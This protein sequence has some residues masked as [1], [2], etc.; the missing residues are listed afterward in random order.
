MLYAITRH[1][2]FTIFDAFLY[3]QTQHARFAAIIS[4]AA[5][6]YAID[7]LF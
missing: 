6:C 2:G 5:A 7:A 4:F 1:A 3:A